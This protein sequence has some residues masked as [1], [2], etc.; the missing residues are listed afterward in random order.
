MIKAY[1]PLKYISEYKSKFFK[2]M[3]EMLEKELS[4][5][6]FNK[7]KAKNLLI[8]LNGFASDEEDKKYLIRLLNLES[9]MITQSRRFAYVKTIYTSRRIPLEEKEKLLER[10]IKRDKNSG[11][12]L[13]A[14]Y[15]C[16]AAL[17]DRANKERLWKKI[18]EE[19]NSDSLTNMEA[20]M[21]GFAPVEQYDLVEDFLKEKFF[22]VLPKIGKNNEAFFVRYF[23][24]Y[25]A[26]SHF[27]DDEIIQKMDK[28]INELKEDKDQA[29]I[30]K[31]LTETC[32]IMK[33]TKISREKCEKYLES[34][35]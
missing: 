24:G 32:E 18:T 13:T 26:P 9:S 23:I 1:L 15:T 12:S 25:L 28:L 5:I 3:K 31:Y 4:Q 29:Q 2:T 34:H 19:S 16:N 11:D 33:R 17:P 7:D 27:T 20:I 8:Y 10:E 35:K 14:K 30:V 6:N 21:M 22:E